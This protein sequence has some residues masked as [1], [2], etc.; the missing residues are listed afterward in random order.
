MNDLKYYS[1]I[2]SDGLTGIRMNDAEVPGL[3]E[4]V[5]YTLDG[6]GKR[7]RPVL[8]LM[9]CEAVGGDA[10]D[11]L[12]AALGVE[13]FH[14]FTLLHDDVMDCSDLRRG[15]PTVHARWNDNTAIL[16]GDAMLTLAT[17]LVM[18]VP[19]TVLRGVL[20]TFNRGALDVYE[21]QAFDMEFETRGDVVSIDEY[22]HMISLKTGALLGTACKIGA[23]AG[24]ASQK[25]A[26]AL[27]EFGMQLGIAFQIHDDYLDM[28][29]D[30]K[31]LG[32]PVGGDVQNGKQ[33]FLLLSALSRGG[34]ESAALHAAMK[35]DRGD[36]K[37]QVFREIYD[38]LGMASICRSATEHYCRKAVNALSGAEI[39]ESDLSA[40]A[41]LANALTDRTQ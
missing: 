19:D 16:S 41:K 4:P 13:M 9:A 11:A 15:R 10:G 17:E 6:G 35:M 37:L 2:I 26:D 32:K 40:F 29:G 25:S 27:Y 1:S 5:R 28:Y 20:D 33:T 23:L 21:G 36:R 12:D 38:S 34:E 14:N 8:A 3:Y 18:H 7:L 31:T 22:I 24:G 39:S 30:V